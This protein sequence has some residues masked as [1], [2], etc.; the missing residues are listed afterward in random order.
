[1]ATNT[2]LNT[3]YLVLTGV[4]VVAI[5][6]LFTVLQPIMDSVNTLRDSIAAD[7]D[8]LARKVEFLSSLE[9]KAQQLRAQPQVEQQLAAIVPDT[10]RSQDIIRLL[11]QYAKES[12][13]TI[14]TVGNS[15]AQS[16]ARAN[17]SRARGDIISVPEGIRTATFQLSMVGSYLQVRSF[18]GGMEKSPRIIDVNHIVITKNPTQVDQVTASLTIQ[19]YSREEESKS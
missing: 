5:V 6:F 2:S 3:P 18:L 4:V 17:A 12:G 15:S 19:M 14:T 1:M 13:V 9:V 11:D 10:E 16:Q 8:A 7:R